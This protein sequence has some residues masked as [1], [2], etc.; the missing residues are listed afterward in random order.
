MRSAAALAT[1][2]T[3]GQAAQARR[4]GALRRGVRA[5]R[6]GRAHGRGADRAAARSRARHRCAAARCARWSTRAVPPTAHPAAPSAACVLAGGGR[7]WL[8][9]KR[10]EP[11]WNRSA[12][13]PRAEEVLER[14]NFSPF[15]P[16][17]AGTQ[18]PR[19]GSRG[20]GS[21]FA[22]P[23]H[24]VV[25]SRLRGNERRRERVRGTTVTPAAARGSGWVGR[26]GGCAGPRRSS[27]GAR[28]RPRTP[29]P[30]GGPRDRAWRARR[31]T[32]CSDSRA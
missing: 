24:E 22:R 12:L 2:S 10:I 21:R 3:G 4:R 31:G 6:R 13:P 20:P 15:V 23:G 11:N 29:A 18:G 25:D 8:R 19:I 9:I 30:G 27:L 16:A 17:K 7:T 28:A 32:T 14:V 1:A 5:R 26:A